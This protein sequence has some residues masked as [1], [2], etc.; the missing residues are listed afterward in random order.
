GLPGFGNFVAEF[1][2]LLGAWKVSRLWTVLACGGLIASAVYA[3]WI[4]QAVFHGANEKKRAFPDLGTREMVVMGALIAVTVW[5]GVYPQP[6]I[7]TARPALAGLSREVVQGESRVAP[8]VSAPVQPDFDSASLL[9]QRSS[10]KWTRST[11]LVLAPSILVSLTAVLAMLWIAFRRQHTPVVLLTVAGLVLSLVVFSLT[12]GHYPVFI[13]SLFLFDPFAAFYFALIGNAA[14]AVALF[15]YGYLDRASERPE[16]FYVLLLLATVGAALLTASCHFVS[17]FLSLEV[18]SVALYGMLAYTR[19][20]ERSIEAGLKYLIL[21][22]T[23]TAFLLFGIAL[24]YLRVGSLDFYAI[25]K[26]L[27]ENASRD[28]LLLAG[29]GLILVGF[30]FKLGMVPFHLWTADV[31]EGAPAPATAFIATVSKASVFALLLRF[32]ARFSGDFPDVLFQILSVIAILSMFVGNL[33][34]LRQENLKRLLAYSSIAH[35]GYM[36]VAFLAGG[37]E[38]PVAVSFYLVV[39]TVTTLGAFGTVAYLSSADRDADSLADYRGLVWRRPW[40]AVGLMGML[41]SLAGIPLTGGFIGKLWVLSSAVESSLWPLLL[42]LILNSAIGLYYYLRVVVAMLKSPEAEGAEA[43]LPF[44]TPAGR[45]KA[46]AAAAVL[47]L[48]LAT[49]VWLGVYPAPLIEFF[50]NAV[51]T[52]QDL[53]F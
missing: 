30:G 11:F 28:L 32:S 19:Q 45:E 20:R 5:L 25:A 34:A 6:V 39:Y 48:L 40:L 38:G 51:G 44:P 17:F 7:E 31:Y 52:L 4:V 10:L 24:V 9:K 16:E 29:L 1:L 21:A 3:L 42:I 14:I 2:T 46:L 13:S 35:L 36:M 26:P 49:L 15:S 8:V 18:L 22:A 27:V 41:F 23:S 50:R 53:Q 33:L 12:L 47:L 37:K 43:V